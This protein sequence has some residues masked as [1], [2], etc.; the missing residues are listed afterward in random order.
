M[1]RELAQNVQGFRDF[2]SNK[3]NELSIQYANL[4][5]VAGG[6]I[7]ANW[8]AAK[9]MGQWRDGTPLVE[10]PGSDKSE[11]LRKHSRHEND[12]SYAL[13]DPQ[14]MHCPFGSHIRRANPRDSLQPD[15]PAQQSITNRH[16]LLRRGR[17]YEYYTEQGAIAEKGLLFVALC[18]D[19]ERQFEFVQQTWIN[20][21]TFHG[22]KNEPDPFV[23]W[24]DPKTRVFTIPTPSGPVR[25]HDMES[26]VSV[27]AGGYF[28]MPSRSAIRYLANLNASKWYSDGSFIDPK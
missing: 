27:Q 1:I 21:S 10:R 16:R 11:S 20:S 2:T 4:A 22:L 24:Q 6:Q 19:L 26:F 25:L 9:M 7:T 28:F 23:A 3:A 8:V 5:D 13:D 14:G 18:T 12:F 17:S 15:D